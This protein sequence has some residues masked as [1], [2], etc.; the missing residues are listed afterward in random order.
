MSKS[1]I[2]PKDRTLL[3]AI[4]PD[5]SGPE[6]NDNEGVLHIPQSSE[7]GVLP[8]NG[9]IS[10]LGT[11]VVEGDLLLCR[12]AVGVFY[13]PCHLGWIF[14]CVPTHQGPILALVYPLIH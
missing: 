1:P 3:S 2:L 13:S 8:S 6:S 11:L 10:C 5:Q 4:T 12:D 9:L 7:A 14:S